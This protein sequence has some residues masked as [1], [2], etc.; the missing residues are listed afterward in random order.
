[1]NI[2]HRY[3]A[4]IDADLGDG[5][6]RMNGLSSLVAFAPLSVALVYAVVFHPDEKPSLFE[7]ALVI[8]P[9]VVLLVVWLWRVFLGAVRQVRAINAGRDPE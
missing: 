3:V 9:T 7:D 4:W 5:W 1:M 6:P 8:P 2:W